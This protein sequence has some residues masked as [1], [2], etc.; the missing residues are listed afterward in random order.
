MLFVILCVIL[1]SKINNFKPNKVTLK[2]HKLSVALGGI[3][4]KTF[5]TLENTGKVGP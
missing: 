2:G 1:L 4:Y 3:M 5:Y